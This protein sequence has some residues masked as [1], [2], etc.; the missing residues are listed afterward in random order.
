MLQHFRSVN[1]LDREQPH[2][3]P[4]T[5]YVGV[6]GN[7]GDRKATL[8]AAVTDIDR[9]PRTRVSR[10]SAFYASRPMGVISQPPFVN[11]VARLETR[12]PAR[13]LLAELQ[14]IERRWGRIR[15]LRWGPRT[16][17]LDILVY[18]NT[19]MDRC[20]LVIP[21]PG[22]PSRPF[23]LYP[24]EEIAPNLEIPG[25]GTPRALR[26]RCAGPAPQRLR[27]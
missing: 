6:G 23:V 15:K 12:L 25:L 5:A 18:G 21:H 4:V 8:S 24:L 3:R 11:A 26:R 17:D 14:G 16:L 10:R 9:L 1:P 22:I 7:L 19:I 27:D 2:E 13:A 20:A